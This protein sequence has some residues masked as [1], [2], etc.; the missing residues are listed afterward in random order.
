MSIVEIRFIGERSE[1]EAIIQ[2]FR[3]SQRIIHE[4]RYKPSRKTK[5]HVL[6]YIKIRGVNDLFVAAGQERG[7]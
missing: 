7:E 2:I 6:K 1:I 3:D 5:G 4:D